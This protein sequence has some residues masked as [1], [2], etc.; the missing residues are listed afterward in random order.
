MRGAAESQWL[1]AQGAHSGASG[2]PAP[3]QGLYQDVRHE[4]NELVLQLEWA[5]S[6][7]M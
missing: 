3:S 7:T 5:M 1:F 2:S 6:F 4:G